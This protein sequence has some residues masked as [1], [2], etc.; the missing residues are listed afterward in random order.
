MGNLEGAR[1]GNKLFISDGGVLCI[2]LG[3]SDRKKIGGDEV[4][5]HVLPGGYCEGARYGK[6]EDGSE[7]LDDS[8]LLY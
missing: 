6:L 8:A 5:R 1:F 3:V 7:E 2:T 4:S